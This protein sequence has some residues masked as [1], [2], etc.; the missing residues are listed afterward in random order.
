MVCENREILEKL[1][2]SFD[3][4]EESAWNIRLMEYSY[5]EADKFRWSL[6][7]FLR[8]IKEVTQMATMELQQEP[9]IASWLKEQKSVLHQDNLI[10]YLFKQ[11]D[12][13]VHRSMLKPGSSGTVGFTKGRGI[14]LGIGFQIDPLQDSE[15]AILRYI[16]HAARKTDFLGIL[17]TDDDFGEYTC[18]QRIWK[19]E[20]FPDSELTE[21]A[22]EAWNKVAC[23]I[24]GAAE[25]LGAKVKEPKFE[26]SHKHAVRIKV[27][28]PEFVKTHLEQAQEHYANEKT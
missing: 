3:R 5:H 18:V 24:Y 16:D 2:S 4:L 1:Q 8:C 28:E 23:L 22:L 13:V 14:K 15:V 9:D 19:M 7:S 12:L 25:K 21:L 26:L 20:P 27:F 6:N 10:S 11:R 17:Y